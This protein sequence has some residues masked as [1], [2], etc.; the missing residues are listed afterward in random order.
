MDNITI[1]ILPKED[2]DEAIKHLKENFVKDAPVANYLKL[3]DSPG[4]DEFFKEIFKISV[5]YKAVNR[6]GSIVG[7]L[8]NRIVL[9][10]VSSS[11]QLYSFSSNYYKQTLQKPLQLPED[12]FKDKDETFCNYIGLAVNIDCIVNIFHLYPNINSYLEDFILSVDRNYRGMGIATKLIEKTFEFAEA[13]ELSVIRIDCTSYFTYKICLALG[14][15]KIAEIPFKS[16]KAGK[17]DSLSIPEPHTMLYVAVKK[18]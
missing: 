5:S 2:E 14:F 12:F 15:H 11:I 9:K 1:S 7:V 17:I 16:I 10:D 6:E 8:I 3:S 4:F 13:N 18:L